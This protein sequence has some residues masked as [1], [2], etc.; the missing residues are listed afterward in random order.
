MSKVE[1]LPSF[2]PIDFDYHLS[3]SAYDDVLRPDANVGG[4]LPVS[5]ASTLL[6]SALHPIDDN[7]VSDSQILSVAGLPPILSGHPDLHLR[8]GVINASR[9]ADANEPDAEKAFFVADLSEVL[10]QHLRWKKCLPEVEPFY[11]TLHAL[12]QRVPD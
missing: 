2:N 8:N 10:M 12:I 1:V 11:G 3:E 5:N 9:L 7:S 6:T 4:V